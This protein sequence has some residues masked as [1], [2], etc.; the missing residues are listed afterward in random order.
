MERRLAAMKQ[1]SFVSDF[2]TRVLNSRY[3]TKTYR[4]LSGS[5]QSA[6]RNTSYDFFVN[7]NEENKSNYS[8]SDLRRGRMEIGGRMEGMSH[9][10]S[11]G[12]KSCLSRSIE[13]DR[14]RASGASNMSLSSFIE[15]NYMLRLREK[16]K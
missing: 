10:S 7:V 16:R 3:R 11:A 9:W 15:H 14:P 2:T 6:C 4:F 12:T 1:M 13:S 8:E 5:I